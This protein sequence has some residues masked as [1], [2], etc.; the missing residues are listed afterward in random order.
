MAATSGHTPGS[1]KHSKMEVNALVAS[2]EVMRRSVPLVES[3][4]WL[5]AAACHGQGRLFYNEVDEPRRIR[6]TKERHAKRICARCP[7]VNECLEHALIR[8]ERY[9]I[10]GGTTADERHHLADRKHFR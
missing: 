3:C 2:G 7:V 4:S 10:W 6:R 9:G 8:P 1:G 5:S